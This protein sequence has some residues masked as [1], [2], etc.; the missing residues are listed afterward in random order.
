MTAQVQ[1]LVTNLEDR[2][3]ER[4]KALEA[5]SRDLQTAAQIARDVSMEQ[6][7]DELLDRVAQLIRERF[8]YYHVGIFLIDEN[9]EYAVLK[10]AGGDAGKLMLANQH[11]LK[12]GQVGIVGYVAQR[13][14]PRIALDVGAD[15]V[16]FRNP[17]LPY[18]RSEM[19]LPIRTSEG[20]IGVL[21]VQSDKVNAF[22]QDNIMIMQ[23]LTDQLGVSIERTRLVQELQQSATAMERSF[24][25]YSGRAWRSYL[26]QQRSAPGYHTVGTGIEPIRQ[27][28]PESLAALAQGNTQVLH[29]NGDNAGEILAVPVRVHGQTIGTLNLRYQGTEIPVE[30]VRLVEEAANRLAMALENAR[31]VQDMRRLALRERQINLI[32]T[33]VSQSVDLDTILQ[34]TIRELGNTLQVPKAFIQIGLL[35]QE[36]KGRERK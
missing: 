17:L 6:N 18:T 4:T 30:T 13:G 34:N 15:A 31:L 2:V 22:D 14:E 7:T 24:Q 9:R 16:H 10:A 33:Q 11:K 3:N 35:S 25:E 23:I 36:D 28:S 5:R 21:D 1:S 27:A 20:I 19:A 29:G 32:S 26:Q 12:V 8:G